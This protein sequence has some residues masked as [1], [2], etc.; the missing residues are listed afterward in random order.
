MPDFVNELLR[1]NLVRVAGAYAVLGWLLIQLAIALETALNLPDWF[2]T[3]LTIL[4]LICFPIALF[5]AW[6]LEVRPDSVVDTADDSPAGA[7]R[8]ARWVDF[9]IMGV[10]GLICVLIIWQTLNS[11]PIETVPIEDVTMVEATVPDRSLSIAVLPFEDFS[12]DR[13]Q[14][15]FANGMSDEIRNALAQSRGLHVISR[16]SAAALQS[17]SLPVREM[18]ETLGVAHLLEGSVRKAG[19]QLRITAQLIHTDTDAQL[20]SQ[21]YD[22]PLSLENIFAIQDEIARAIVESL[23]SELEI[24][25]QTGT[26]RAQSIEAYEL[27]LRAREQMHTR[28]PETL[29]AAI[30]DF[31]AVLALDPAFAPAYAGL[32]DTLLLSIQ[33]A[34]ADRVPAMSEARTYLD[35]AVTLAPNAVDTLTAQASLAIMTHDYLNAITYAKRAVAANPNLVLAHHRLSLA[36]HRAGQLEAAIKGYETAIALDPLYILFSSNLAHLK[37]IT[38]ANDEAYALAERNLRLHPDSAIPIGTLAFLEWYNG[39]YA[40]AYLNIARSLQL[41]PQDQQIL[42]L[43]RIIELDLRLENEKQDGVHSPAELAKWKLAYDETQG[44]DDLLPKID[45]PMYKLEISYLA[46]DMDLALEAATLFLPKEPAENI[47]PRPKTFPAWAA[48]ADIYIQTDHPDS[49]RV[50]QRLE[51]Y[52]TNYPIEQ[53]GMSMHF[54]DR[55]AVHALRSEDAKAIADLQAYLDAGHVSPWLKIYPAF[56]RLRTRP[57]FQALINK[58]SANAARHRAEIKLLLAD[59]NAIE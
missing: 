45:A 4:V 19:S 3:L 7:G 56:D 8:P 32:A 26:V 48:A 38:G 51:A 44:I 52:F 21:T 14:S 58:N 1:R 12:P 24:G 47:M 31:K 16:A 23:T 33:Y 25:D 10:L 20:W 37:T 2:D 53:T 29:A 59:T 27:Y 43:A 57:E 28:K 36:L 22:R 39:H 9:G 6:A 34:G 30:V 15:Y 35:L 41:N 17:R 40:K 18:G 50:L 5:L 49:E 46:G 42:Q 54:F 55:A 13:D 11:E